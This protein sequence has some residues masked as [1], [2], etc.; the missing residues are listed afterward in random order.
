MKKITFEELNDLYSSPNIFRL[1]KSRS[2]M[3]TGH[4]AR[5]GKERLIQGVGGETWGKETTWETQ[6]Q[7]GR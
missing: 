7:M 3:W 4:V 6:S 5:R 2:M 1:I